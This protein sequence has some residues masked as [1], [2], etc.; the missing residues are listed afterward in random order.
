[1]QVGP[2]SPAVINKLTRAIF[3]AG[4]FVPWKRG[5]W[6]KNRTREREGQG[7]S[8]GKTARCRCKSN[9]P[10]SL[11]GVP[12]QPH[13]NK[14]RSPGAHSLVSPPFGIHLRRETQPA[15]HSLAS[16]PH[17]ISWIIAAR[18]SFVTRGR[19]RS[20]APPF[21]VSSQGTHQIDCAVRATNCPFCCLPEI[22]RIIQI[23]PLFG[24]AVQMPFR[25]PY[26]GCWWCGAGASPE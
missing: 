6:I 2:H 19:R 26:G 4:F 21:G 11:V 17:H 3:V 15:K 10:E 1:M 5:G 9:A 8:P 12:A 24:N 20:A 23:S 18:P 14:T 7:V 16:L 13:R 25:V 22:G